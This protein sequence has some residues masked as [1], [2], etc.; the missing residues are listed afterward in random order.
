MEPFRIV[1]VLERSEL[2]QLVLDHAFDHARRHEAPE[3]HFLAVV[4][5]LDSLDDT[6]DWMITQALEELDSFNGLHPDWSGQIHVARG[7][8]EHEIPAYARAI[9]AHLIVLGAG[10]HVGRVAMAAPCPL[11]IMSLDEPGLETGICPDCSAIRIATAGER[12]FCDAHASDHV[13]LDLPT[14]AFISGGGPLL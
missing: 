6:R 3:I 14:A 12:L 2:T 9:G 11:L 4:N 10:D 13:S 7:Q 1:A 8:L 5:D